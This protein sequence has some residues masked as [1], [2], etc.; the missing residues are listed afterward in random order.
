LFSVAVLVATGTF[1]A[2]EQLGTLEHL[3]H[4]QYGA[5][6]L[7]K[8]AAVAVM[9][10][11]GAINWRMLKPKLGTEPAARAIRRS[12]LREMSVALFILLTPAYLSASSPHGDDEMDPPPAAASR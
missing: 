4:T 9:M 6:L 11:I 1:S 12:A 7:V 3:F 5:Q 10:A 8:L 2:W